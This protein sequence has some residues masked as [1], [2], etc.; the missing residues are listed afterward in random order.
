MHHCTISVS[1]ALCFLDWAALVEAVDT[2]I[3]KKITGL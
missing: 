2:A 3:E 1:I